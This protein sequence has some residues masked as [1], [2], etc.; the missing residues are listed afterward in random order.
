MKQA[1]TAVLMICLGLGCGYLFAEDAVLTSAK[2]GVKADGKSDDGPAIMKMVEEARALKGKPVRLVFPKNKVIH[3]ATGK[4]R[5]LFALQ[6]TRNITIDGGGSTFLLDPRIRMMDLDYAVNPVI[7][8]VKVDYTVTMFIESVIEAVDPKGAY[9]D[10]K[11]LDPGEEKSLGGPTKEDGEQWF[12]GFVWCENGK[13][14]KAATHYAVKAAE[15]LGKDRAR[16]FFDG[17]AIPEQ[18]S[19]RIK[20]GKT[21]FSIPRPGVAQRYGPGPLFNIHDTV[22]GHFENIAVWGAPWFTYS[23]YRCEGVLRFINVDVVPKPGANRLMAGCRDAFHVTGNRSKLVFDGC[24]TAGLGDDDYNFC[25]LSSKIIKV[26]SPTKVVIKQ[27]FPIQYNPMRLGETLMVMSSENQIVGSATITG[28]D[29]KPHEDGAK[30]IP[31]GRYCPPVTITLKTPIKGLTKGLHA[32]NKEAANPDTT[33]K[34]CTAT[35]SIRMQT[36]LTIDRCKFTC[37]NVAYGFSPR[38]KHVEGPGPEFLKI[39]NSTFNVGRGS[40]MVFQSGG[41]GLFETT[42]IQNISIEN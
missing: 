18:I 34:N 7:K 17:K 16:I 12:G 29:E 1:R 32:W 9:V 20:V 13:H 26:I 21:R 33:M 25:I 31:G 15:V 4:E 42:R 8:N 37:Y 35:F 28:Y 39:T 6:H 38:T 41:N 22:D 24:D 19:G 3:V 36:S 5:Y 27:K 11:L 2:F 14:M 10:V 30:I 23:I 40:G